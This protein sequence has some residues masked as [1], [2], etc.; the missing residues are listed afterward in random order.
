MKSDWF[1]KRLKRLAAKMVSL[2]FVTWIAVTALFVR[3]A[4]KSNDASEYFFA[5]LGFTAAV[6]GIKSYK[7]VRAR[8]SGTFPD[9]A[10]PPGEGSGPEAD[11]TGENRTG[12]SNEDRQN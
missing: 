3:L 6:I 12:G 2:S 7:D 9:Y 11:M 5:Y 4:E 1:K 8:L 10:V